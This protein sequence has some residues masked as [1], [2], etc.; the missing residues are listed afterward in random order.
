MVPWSAS[1]VRGL[2]LRALVLRA[3]AVDPLV[4]LDKSLLRQ[5]SPGFNIFFYGVH[6]V[7]PFSSSGAISG[8]PDLYQLGDHGK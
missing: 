6:V 1:R 4:L 7:R 5:L 8:R 2:A 3:G